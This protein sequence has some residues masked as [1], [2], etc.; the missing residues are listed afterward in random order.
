MSYITIPTQLKCYPN[1]TMDYLHI[2]PEQKVHQVTIKDIN[3]KTVIET[4]VHNNC[5]SIS[6]LK[7]GVYFMEATSPKNK[8]V[9]KILKID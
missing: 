3:A 4:T 9:S 6:Q 2:N 8:F 1:P 7:A 5:I